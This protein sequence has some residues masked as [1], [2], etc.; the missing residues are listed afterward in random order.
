MALLLRFMMNDRRK[1]ELTRLSVASN[2]CEGSGGIVKESVGY[3]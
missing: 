2:M 1:G 3:G